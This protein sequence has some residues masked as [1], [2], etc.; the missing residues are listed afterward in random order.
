ML[1]QL[2]H[3]CPASVTLHIPFTLPPSLQIMWQMDTTVRLF[4]QLGCSCLHRIGSQVFQLHCAVWGI[5]SVT[6]F[7][8]AAV[9]T[10]SAFF[11]FYFFLLLKFESLFICLKVAASDRWCVALEEPP[12]LSYCWL[13]GFSLMVSTTLTITAVFFHFPCKKSK[14][15]LT[16]FI[17]QKL[18]PYF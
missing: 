18:L 3:T 2:C 12:L 13:P 16:H 11:C 14:L 8:P 4:L 5:T 15:D 6:S 1:A 10:C 9:R 17:C 7:L